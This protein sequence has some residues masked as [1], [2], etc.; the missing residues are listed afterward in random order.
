MVPTAPVV[1]EEVVDMRMQSGVMPEAQEAQV[2]SY[3]LGERG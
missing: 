2:L 3:F 1:E